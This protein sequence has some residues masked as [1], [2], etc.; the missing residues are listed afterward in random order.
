MMCEKCSKYFNL[1]NKKPVSLLCC[2]NILCQ[3]CY[4]S[5]FSGQP[6]LTCPFDCQE[7]TAAPPMSVESPPYCQ[8]LL[9]QMQRGGGE[10]TELRCDAHP[11]R[12]VEYY[13][14]RCRK[15]R[16]TQCVIPQGVTKTTKKDIERTQELLVEALDEQKAK[17]SD[18]YEQEIRAIEEQMK[19]KK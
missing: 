19:R 6:T 12:A 14:K 16:C 13:D 11:G 7:D 5:S 1:L 15:Y 17:V 8:Y 4:T 2:H 9:K 10:P 18:R 3:E